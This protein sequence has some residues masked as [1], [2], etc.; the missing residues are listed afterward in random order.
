MEARASLTGTSVPKT[1]VAIVL[2]VIAMGLAAMSGYMARGLGG[3]AAEAQGQPVHAAP[4]TVLRQDA[5]EAQGQ[6]VHA[7]PGTVLRQDNPARP[8]AHRP[9][10]P[11]HGK[12]PTGHPA[13]Q[14]ATPV[15]APHP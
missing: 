8:S 3:G 2:V 11:P 5:A 9:H 7:A 1:F 14:P 10:H 4:G 15:L 13:L 12:T 6:P